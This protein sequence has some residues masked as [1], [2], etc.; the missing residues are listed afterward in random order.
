MAQGDRRDFEDTG[1]ALEAPLLAPSFQLEDHLKTNFWECTFNLTKVIL[2]AGIMALPKAV[3][4]LGWGLGM[5][6]LVVVGLLTH[7]TVH[8]LV[9]ASDRCRRDTYSA[10]TRTALGPLAEKVLQAA[11]LLGCLGFEVV[12]IDIIG[13]LLIGDEPDRDGLVTAWLPSHLRHEWWV[14]RPFVLAILTVAVLA[15]LTSLRTMNHLGAV[16]V[17][18]LLSLVGFAGATCWLGLAAVTQ[19]SAY[20]MPFGPDM[21]GLGPD[22][23]SRI[24]S[25]LA[26]VPILLTAA[27]CHQSVHPLRAM[28]VPYNPAVLDR[29]VALSLTMVTVL[30]M[31]V[32][33]AAYTAFG[34]DVRGNFL[35]NL[36]PAQLSPL[37]GSTAATVVSFGVK[38]GYAGSLIGSSVLIMFPLRQSTLEVVAP[39]QALPG[40]PPVP[41]SLYLSCTYGLLVATY[42]I[43]VFVPSIWDVISFVGAVSCTI[44]CFIIPAVL[45][46][47][48]KDRP[49]MSHVLQRGAACWEN[50]CAALGGY[51][52]VCY[53][54][55]GAIIACK[56]FGSGQ[57]G[58]LEGFEAVAV[59]AEG[60]GFAGMLRGHA[61]N[62]PCLCRRELPLRRLVV[63]GSWFGIH[64]VFRVG[65]WQKGYEGRK[66]IR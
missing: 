5:S 28:L 4:M 30:F 37:I 64:I 34:Q 55:Q 23:A 40:A 1:Q 62:M 60:C 22:T 14:G 52:G 6:L 8:G 24:T 65:A 3:A 20:Q 59:V 46:L 11:M 63:C 17:V 27:S 21:E 29:V 42:G 66:G 36:S 31:V 58:E 56:P 38:G 35:N 41:A 9:Y 50:C 51:A 25:A 16:N 32:A 13:D 57:A 43:A 2:G 12:Y 33:Y 47:H 15:P 39:A 45:I 54:V 53:R 10:L 19:G 44:M 7:F 61:C 48:F 18:G 49:T 26:V